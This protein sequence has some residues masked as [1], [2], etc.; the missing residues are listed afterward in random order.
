M[1]EGSAEPL[2]GR[3]ETHKK[4]DG[5]RNRG[6]WRDPLT[7]VALSPITLLARAG[8]VP[9]T[10]CGALESVSWDAFGGKRVS[11]FLLVK[12]CWFK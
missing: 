9:G 7:A 2:P 3:K 1:D 6:G 5:G 4:R 12:Q 8:A 10:A 11:E